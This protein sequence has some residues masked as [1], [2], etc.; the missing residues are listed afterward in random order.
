MR[1]AGVFITLVVFAD[2]VHGGILC[3]FSEVFKINGVY[4]YV[5]VVGLHN[6]L[7][8]CGTNACISVVNNDMLQTIQFRPML[9]VPE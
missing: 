4:P 5:A 6:L 3:V 2:T 9:H 7:V 1:R 8:L